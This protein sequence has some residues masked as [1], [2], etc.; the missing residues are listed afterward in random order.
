[1]ICYCADGLLSLRKESATQIDFRPQNKSTHFTP[2]EKPTRNAHRAGLCGTSPCQNQP[3]VY[4]VFAAS[5]STE[6]H[7]GR[8]ARQKP[9][10]SSTRPAGLVP[11]FQ[12]PPP[13]PSRAR[14]EQPV[15]ADPVACC[16]VS[17]YL[18][19]FPV[20]FRVNY[21]VNKPI[22]VSE[23]CGLSVRI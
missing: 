2:D 17:Y 15:W 19:C 23:S 9:A 11:T 5:Q 22:S 6:P 14:S 8:V 20:S 3:T 13:A 10:E 1:M 16:F 21:A 18:P 7:V 12:Q 4:A